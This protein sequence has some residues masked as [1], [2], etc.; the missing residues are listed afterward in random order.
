MNVY[1][2]VV[3]IES[4]AISQPR[5]SDANTKAVDKRLFPSEVG[6][7]FFVCYLSKLVP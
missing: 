5:I 2:R 7:Q 4:V 3:W 6:S 1:A